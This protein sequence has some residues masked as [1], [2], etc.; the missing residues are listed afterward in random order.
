MLEVT[1]GTKNRVEVRGGRIRVLKANARNPNWVDI[2]PEPIIVGRN[3]ACQLV[4][5]DGK[6]SAVHAE[7]VATEQGVRLR[8]LGSRNGTFIAGVRVADVFLMS[9]T[10]MRLGETEMQFEPVRPERI[11]VSALPAFGPMVA[12]SPSMRTIFEKLSKVAPTDLTVLITGET[13]TGKELVAQAVHLASPR[14]KKPF[15]IVDCGSIPPTLAEATLFGHERGA[16][17]GAVDKRL[18]P[19]LEADGGTIFLDELGELPIDVQP[20]LLRALAERRIK[21]VGGS[22]YREV[23]VR[24]LAATRRDLVRA[25]N[26]GAFRSDLYFRVA[27]VKVELP[28]L[29]QRIEDIPVLVRKMLRDLGDESAYDRVTN[30]TLERLM[31]HDW[32]GNVRE[33]KNAVQV[34]SALHVEGEEVD[35]ASHL[36]SLAETPQASPTLGASSSSVS[37]GGS[38]PAAT[39]KGRPFQ[40]AKRD[41]LARFE[42]D[43]FAALAEEAKG[44]VSEMARRAGME[45]AHVRAYLRRH[46]ILSKG[47]PSEQE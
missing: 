7:F 27:Q 25:V 20:K 15:V 42:R 12:Q 30:E 21:S 10:K 38:I 23:D 46:E 43:Y 28:A 1:V 37:S 39:F 26:T 47:E 34:A 29:R 32:P 31:R 2:G 40:E 33:L 4:L 8:D 11:T 14:A 13:G 35:I 3:A 17:T 44:N 19:F 36:G 18:S 6:V 22:S 5:E 41:V 24:V 16:F 9:N 45:R